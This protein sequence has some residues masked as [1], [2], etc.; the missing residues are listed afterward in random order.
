MKY[1]FDY[2]KQ[3]DQILKETR[4]VGFEE[5]I[6]LIESGGLIADLKHPKRA[7]QRLFFLSIDKLVYVVPY[8][9]D[10]KR[11]LRFLKTAYPSTKFTKLYQ[12][13][14]KFYKKL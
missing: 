9:Y 14:K 6:D 7:N 2:S 10:S 13:D 1:K 12:K 8:V 5:I 11:A 4:G 3:K